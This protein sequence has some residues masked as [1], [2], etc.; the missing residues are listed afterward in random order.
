MVNLVKPRN[1]L[2]VFYQKEI[3]RYDIVQKTKLTKVPN[4][5]CCIPDFGSFHTLQQNVL[6]QQ[7]IQAANQ[8]L[9]RP[10]EH[11]LKHESLSPS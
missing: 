7:Y 10:K 9:Q 6:D 8:S 1:L 2:H 11:S 5:K 4:E 3:K